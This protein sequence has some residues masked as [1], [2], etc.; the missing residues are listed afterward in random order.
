M[1]KAP[2]KSMSIL[3]SARSVNNELAHAMRSNDG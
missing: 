1:D 3:V 2:E